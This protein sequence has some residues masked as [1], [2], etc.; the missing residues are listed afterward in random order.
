MVLRFAGRSLVRAVTVVVAFATPL[1]VA[2]AQRDPKLPLGEACD[3]LTERDIE[4]AFGGPVTL[5]LYD[6]LGLYDCIR[7]RGEGST[8]PGGGQFQFIQLFPGLPVGPSN[9][10]DIVDDQRA[11]DA[12]ANA[13]LVD[14]DGLGR[15]AYVNRT[16]GSLVVAATKK[17]AFK[18]TWTDDDP[19]AGLT[20]RDEKK[21]IK[22]ARK[23]IKRAPK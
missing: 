17:Y 5:V 14:L 18:L 1:G 19:T 16:E 15:Q 12:L 6:P 10:R 2:A 4:K 3:I 21:L 8:V 7:K 9:A 20:R 23:L 11:F 22:I 13:E